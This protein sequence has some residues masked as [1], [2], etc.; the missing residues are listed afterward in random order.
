[1]SF[2]IREQNR[3]SA[4]LTP[5]QLPCLA[6]TPSINLT[7]GCAHGCIYC[8]ARSYSL[9]PG[10]G[11][12]LVYSDTA[13]RLLSELKRKRKKPSHV[14]FSPSTDVFQPIDSVLDMAYR[15]FST[16]LEQGIGVAFVSKGRI[17]ER[18]MGLLCAHAALVRSQI[19]VI[20]PDE[21]LARRIEPH[22]ASPVV[23]FLQMERL[24]QAGI[25]TRVRIAPIIPGLTDADETL[26]TL[27]K[28]ASHSGAAHATINAMHLR[29]AITASLRK[30]LETEDFERVFS[31]YESAQSLG[32]CGGKSRQ[33]PLSLT[34][35][36]RLFERTRCI[37][38]RYDIAV[39][40]C[41]CM[42]PDLTNEKCALDGEWSE[43]SAQ[44]SQMALFHEAH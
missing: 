3:K 15:M 23:R 40:V 6:K 22:A 2:E 26:D 9:F 21:A 34:A 20:T 7:L 11:N 14:Y 36:R 33:K 24:I 44:E 30:H 1:M 16:L 38:A 17:P 19:G 29:P 5:S 28:K 27:F 4:V 39:H 42:N 31:H 43:E 37:A 13:E 35:R 32:V 41:G 25:P 10:E 18:H 8:Y 12:V